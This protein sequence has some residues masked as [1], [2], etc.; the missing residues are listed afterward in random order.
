MLADYCLT[1]KMDL[2]EVKYSRKSYKLNIIV[3]KPLYRCIFPNL[4]KKSYKE[5]LC[6]NFFPSINSC[7]EALELPK[8]DIRF[9]VTKKSF[10]FVDQ[11]Y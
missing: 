4:K 1:L 5:I 7:W 3:G 8:L 2:P 10:N 9:R 11:C 6:V